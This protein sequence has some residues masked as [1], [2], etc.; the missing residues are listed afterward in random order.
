MLIIPQSCVWGGTEGNEVSRV[1]QE[2]TDEVVGE[3]GIKS[4]LSLPQPSSCVS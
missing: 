2:L 1:D 3:G 4:Y